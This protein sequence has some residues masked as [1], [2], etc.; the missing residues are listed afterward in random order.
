M[1]AELKQDNKCSSEFV[2]NSTIGQGYLKKV[3]R[4]P[5]NKEQ[6]SFIWV[7]DEP[8]VR[9]WIEKSRPQPVPQT[10][11]KSN[12]LNNDLPQSIGTAIDKQDTD[13]SSLETPF[14]KAKR[15]R[16]IIDVPE[17][18]EGLYSWDL[19][20]SSN[21][22]VKWETPPPK[23][24]KVSPISSSG[25]VSAE[26]LKSFAE[27]LPTPTSRLHTTSNRSTNPQHQ[28]LQLDATPTPARFKDPAH[29]C[30]NTE[31]DLTTI[32]LKLIRSDTTEL[33][34]STEIQLRHEI[35]LHLDLDMAKEQRHK[36]VIS[37]LS[38]RVEELETLVLQLT[39]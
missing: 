16:V 7:D 12:I 2:G 20:G 6:C 39:E 24:A 33:K 27:S 13:R 23:V 38:K 35:E 17:P 15:K 9:E 10:P 14:T 26:R 30:F 25:Q 22:V 1:S 3:W 5:N 18:L 21:P 31:S 4:C 29:L 28:P 8:A 11:T 36:D 34:I 32:I 19:G 37:R